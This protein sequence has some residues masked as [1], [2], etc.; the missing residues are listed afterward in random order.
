MAIL[1]RKKAVEYNSYWYILRHFSTM[2][3]RETGG[4]FLS[5]YSQGIGKKLGKF[6]SYAG[7]ADEYI[8]IQ[9]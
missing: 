5:F 8:F 9:V 2:L 7:F 1:N 4:H 6:I 3:Y